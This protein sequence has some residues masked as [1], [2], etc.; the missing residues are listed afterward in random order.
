M[1]NVVITGAL[2]HIGSRLIHSLVP[3]EFG[4]VLLVD[5]LR[6]QRY[7]S[8]FRLPR[9]VPFEFVE[10][11]ICTDNLQR[12]FS[13]S[14][15][16]IHLA[17]ITNAAGS[18]ENSEEVERVNLAGT[19]R[20]ANACAAAGCR[21]IALST[22]SVYGV[23]AGVVDEDCP[24][25]Q[26]KPQSPYAESKLR[27]ERLLR[28][29]GQSDGLRFVTCRFGTIY[30]TSIGMRFHTAVNKF[31]W[32]ACLGKPLTVWR[33]ALDQ[34]RPYLD[35]GDAVDALK[36][37]LQTDRFD[38][39]VYNVLTENATVRQVVAAIRRSIPGV[40]VEEVDSPIMNQLSYTVSCEKFRRLGFTFRGSL[41]AGIRETIDLLAGVQEIPSRMLANSAAAAS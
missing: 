16:V 11:D 4:R 24:A 13:G 27:A 1:T 31:A 40:Q 12:L 41:E 30:G 25:E 9:G 37:I 26:L 21:L 38:N 8:L 6:T 35:L 14:D 34:L 10:A 2:G 32:Q 18:F 29:L 22:T 20:V 36:F 3:G 33:A 7:C 15:A 17:A 5:N 39:N 19:E 28:A 23:S